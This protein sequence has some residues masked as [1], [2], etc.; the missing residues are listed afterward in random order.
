[1]IYLFGRR[2]RHKPIATILDEIIMQERLGVE[3]VF[4]CDDNFIGSHQYAKDLLRELIPLNNSFDKPLQ[5]STQLSIDAAKDDELL[6]LLADANFSTLCIGIE[7]VNKGSLKEANKIQNYR[8]DLVKACKKI[9]SY[10]ININGSMIVGFDHDDPAV[11]DEQFEFSQEVC[12]PMLRIN[13]L[14]AAAGTR[15]WVRLLKEGRI[16][17]NDMEAYT[18]NPRAGT[19]IIPAKMTRMEL[20]TGFG[21]LQKRLQDWHN[22]AARI[23]GFV[24]GVRRPP[25]VSQ[26][27]PPEELFSEVMNFLFSVDKKARETMIDIFRYTREHAPFMLGRVVKMTMMQYSDVTFSNLSS[28]EEIDRLIEL[29]AGLDIPSLIDRRELLIPESFYAKYDELFPE[30]YQRVHSVLKDKEDTS[31]ALVEVFTDFVTH[32]GG[33]FEQT[34]DHHRVFLLS[35]ADRAAMKWKRDQRGG[36]RT[37]EI[38]ESELAYIILKGVEQNSRGMLSMGMISSTTTVSIPAGLTPLIN[39]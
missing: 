32:W 18:A 14:K 22:F 29:E 23:K 5:F 38:N 6:E 34:E 2:P 4:I 21:E 39:Y 3:T 20:L 15:L 31:E 24:S 30:I 16:L 35:L 36:S 27:A 9:Q 10:G 7:S 13:M 37:Q 19:N 25:N 28:P 12:I 17:H 33:N 26:K 8:V 1:V 11:F